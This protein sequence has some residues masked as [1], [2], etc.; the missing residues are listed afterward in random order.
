VTEDTLPLTQRD[1]GKEKPVF[2][3][4]FARVRPLLQHESKDQ[5]TFKKVIT[6]HSQ[7]EKPHVKVPTSAF[8]GNNFKSYHFQNVFDEKVD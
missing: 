6:T 7:G 1:A 2:I 8:F 5:V 3:K 4:V